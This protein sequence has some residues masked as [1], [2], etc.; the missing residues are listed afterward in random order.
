MTEYTEFDVACDLAKVGIVYGDRARSKSTESNPQ[1]IQQVVVDGQLVAIT[2]GPQSILAGGTDIVLVLPHIRGITSI[3]E[4]FGL[5]RG[6]CSQFGVYVQGS[7]DPITI[8]SGTALDYYNSIDSL[9]QARHEL[10]AAINQYHNRPY[11]GEQLS[12]L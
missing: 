11:I 6:R 2:V 9:I 3:V 5:A 12:L 4:T 8:Y 7:K 10:L 1:I